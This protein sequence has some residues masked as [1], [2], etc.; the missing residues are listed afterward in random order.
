[1]INIFHFYSYSPKPCTSESQSRA[2]WK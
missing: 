2:I 1:M